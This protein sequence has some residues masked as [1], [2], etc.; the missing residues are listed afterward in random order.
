MPI[1][2]RRYGINDVA[3]ALIPSICHE[4]LVVFSANTTNTTG[5]AI[6]DF[7]TNRMLDNE[8]SGRARVDL[9]TEID[10]NYSEYP[11]FYNVEALGHAER[12]ELY[13][14]LRTIAYHR[15]LNAAYD[16]SIPVAAAG[17]TW[18]TIVPQ[19]PW[20]PLVL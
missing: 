14:I 1:D 4:R 13:L 20:T 15:R 18:V 3:V 2:Y 6:R 17:D 7:V 11:P 10:R 9:E 19:L 8:H 5:W 16:T 12:W